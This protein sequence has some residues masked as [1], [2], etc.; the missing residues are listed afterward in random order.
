VL[1]CAASLWSADLANLAA[2]I[3]RIEPF[4]ERFHLD[5]ADGHYVKN[6]LFFPDLVHA[7]RRHTSRPF[8]AH[9]MVADPLAWI[10]PFAQAG[11]DSLIFCLDSA[12]SPARVIDAIRSR[13]KLAGVS[14]RVEEPVE[15][16]EPYLRDLALV[17]LL[18]TELGI[19]G[20][21]MDPRLPDKIRQARAMLARLRLGVEI[22]A[23][24]GIRRETVPLIHAAGADVIVPGSL[25]FGGDPAELRRWLASL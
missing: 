12:A 1:K 13:D 8:E 21:G 16:A 20:V 9:L 23:D 4:C 18:G 11:A 10:E 22:E 3:K 2:E 5:V 14:L 7:L 24:G 6:L 19:K 15:L 17:T 25:L